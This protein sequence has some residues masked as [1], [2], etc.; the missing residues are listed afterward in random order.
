ME[1]VKAFRILSYSSEPPV[2]VMSVI[3]NGDVAVVV[4]PDHVES[5]TNPSSQIAKHAEMMGK[6]TTA[7]GWAN[8]EGYGGSYYGISTAPAPVGS[9]IQSLTIQ[10]ED[11]IGVDGADSA[12][13]EGTLP[14]NDSVDEMFGM[15]PELAEF[16]SSGEAAA[17]PGGMREYVKFILESN[18]ALELN[19]A[20]KD[21]LAGGPPPE[22]DT[23]DGIIWSA[24]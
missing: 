21:W 7:A 24:E 14:F 18:G 8:L 6:P 11:A 5:S 23:F 4:Y 13:S 19:P 3:S 10:E 1:D 2:H 16:L 12:P 20:L 9:T 22:D 15:D 17:E